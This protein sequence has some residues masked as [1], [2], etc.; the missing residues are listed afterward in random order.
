MEIGSNVGQ[1]PS[2]AFLK[3]TNVCDSVFDVIQKGAVNNMSTNSYL[4]AIQNAWVVLLGEKIV[5]DYYASGNY[6]LFYSTGSIASN[7]LIVN[8][9]ANMM[10]KNDNAPWGFDTHLL[11]DGSYAA[12]AN[13]STSSK[14]GSSSI[15]AWYD[16]SGD[17]YYLSDNGQM[18]PLTTKCPTIMFTAQKDGVYKVNLACYRPNPNTSV[19]N[20]LYIRCRFMDSNTT[21][22]SK[23]DYIFAKQ[24]G[25]I[26]SDGA[27]GKAPIEMNYFINMKQGDKLTFEEDA[28]TANN[29]SSAA[30][31]ITNL[32]ICSC[33]TEDSI[34]TVDIA[35]ASG[36]DFYNPYKAGDGTELKSVIAKADSI[37]AA[38]KDK[39]GPAEGQYNTDA[40]NTLTAAITQAN[41][42]I[43]TSGTTQKQFDD[44]VKAITNAI[45][46]FISSRLPFEK[47]ISGEYGIRLAGTDKFL[48]QNNSANGFY[49]ANFF[50]AEGAAKDAARFSGVSVSD[51]NWTFTFTKIDSLQGTNITNINGYLSLD[52]YVVAG[53]DL[54][55]EYHTFQFYTQAASD[56]LFAIK[57]AD[58]LYWGNT[59]NWVAP[60]NKIA[61]STTP[62]FIFALDIRT[63]TSV[64]S[65]SND[66]EAKQVSVK[67]YTIDGRLANERQKGI[68]IKCITF[69][70][71]SMKTTKIIVK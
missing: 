34:F 50:N 16:N 63:L 35:Q 51:Y 49:Y 70:D 24:Y 46:T 53:E 8:Y 4:K 47:L 71:G 48:C 36:L 54:T 67:Y 10:E 58:G 39:V 17:W 3:F 5:T 28:Y 52:A 65:I 33:V 38:D 13:H 11:S 68:L 29:I 37:V 62:Q 2:S 64:N 30:T 31:Q 57:R 15:K 20:P 12:M 22:C 25:S 32:S 9:D 27:K 40:F 26:V 45:S 59:V 21:K 19:N 60:Y 14:F 43:Q 42:L 69:A 7:N 44:E 23:S 55:P 18:H 66:T 61:T 6:R 56:T 41:A 1:F